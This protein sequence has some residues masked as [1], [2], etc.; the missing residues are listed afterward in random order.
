MSIQAMITECREE[1]EAL[2]NQIYAIRGDPEDEDLPSP[3][4]MSDDTL[5]VKHMV[6]RRILKGHFG[7]IYALHWASDSKHLVSASQDGKLLIWNAFAQLKKQAIPLQ[8][9]WVM[10][11]AYSPDMDKVCCGGLDNVCSVYDI[12][13]ED[14]TGDAIQK[15]ALE[16]THH[17]G[18]LSCAR[19]LSASQMIT[20]SGDQSCLLWDLNTAKPISEFK[21]HTS[22]VMSVSVIP[23][24]NT[25]ISGACDMSA[26]LWD[27][28]VEN[29]APIAS[30]G[31]HQSD[32]NAVEYFPDGNSFA[33]AS[34]DAFA[35]M[36]DIRSFRQINKFSPQSESITP[37]TC[38]AF[39]LTGRMLFTGYD[40]KYC[41]VW[42]T[43]SNSSVALGQ[44]TG[45][46]QRVSCIGVPQDGSALCTGSWDHTMKVW[47]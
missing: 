22:D 24:N 16:L 4:R 1:I 46:E 28:R 47:A 27:I 17:D 12:S 40:A 13:N 41:A 6:C 8:Q 36:F 7:K 5:D 20:S 42:D 30:F 34:D 26:K 38:V 44:L 19:F 11:A 29:S 35:R 39:S 3:L 15:K 25:F 32:V 31:G 33:T 10:T 43:I 9:S 45:H 23:G 2:Q 37:V 18:Y 21:G 14:E